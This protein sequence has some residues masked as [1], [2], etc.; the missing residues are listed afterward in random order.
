MPPPRPLPPPREKQIVT[1][2]ERHSDRSLAA[3][4]KGTV[5]PF[6]IAM[7]NG[8]IRKALVLKCFIF[9]Y[10]LYNTVNI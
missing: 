5:Q 3:S 10:N 7:A 1:V 2:S 9:L 4:L 6:Y 8:T